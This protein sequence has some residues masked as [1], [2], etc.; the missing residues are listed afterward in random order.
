MLQEKF[1]ISVIIIMNPVEDPQLSGGFLSK[2]FIGENAGVERMVF[3]DQM[4][5]FVGIAGK[6]FQTLANKIIGITKF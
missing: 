2:G 1:Q 4:Q 6:R 5:V 3:N